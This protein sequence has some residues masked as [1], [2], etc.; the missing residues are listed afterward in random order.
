MS[1]L[2]I[3]VVVGF[4]TLRKKQPAPADFSGPVPPAA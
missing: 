2:V 3:P 4:V 1:L